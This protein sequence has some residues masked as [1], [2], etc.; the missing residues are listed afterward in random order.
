[1]YLVIHEYFKWHAQLHIYFHF[2]VCICWIF[3]HC[4]Y[5]SDYWFQMVLYPFCS[6]HKWYLV[7]TFMCTCYFFWQLPIFQSCYIYQLGFNN[8]IIDV[9]I[10]HKFYM[11]SEIIRSMDMRKIIQMT[12]LAHYSDQ[13]VHGFWGTCFFK[14]PTTVTSLL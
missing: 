7:I 9:K 10:P 13:H 5:Q 11:C 6:I 3:L 2:L 8:Y 12:Q 4:T 1:M 14:L